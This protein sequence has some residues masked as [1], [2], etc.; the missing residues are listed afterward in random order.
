MNKQLWTY[1]VITYSTTWTIV[2]G[3]YF[4]YKQ[5]TITLNQLNINF[6]LGSLGPFLSAI[7]TT[8]LFYKKDGLHKLFAT[9]RP[10]RLNKK[11]LLLSCSPLLF[12]LIGWLL[13]PL[14]TGKWFSFDTTKQQFHLTNTASYLG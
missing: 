11:T 6:T 4:L 9:L 5:N 8:K 14:L 2:I 13:Y 12:L 3:I 10:G 1:I 7:I